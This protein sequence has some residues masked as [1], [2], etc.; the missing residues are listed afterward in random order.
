MSAMRSICFKMP[1]AALLLLLLLGACSAEPARAEV[2]AFPGAEGAGAMS[3]GGRGGRAIH[4][5]NLDDSGPGSLRSAID[6]SG[7]RTVIFDLGG[8]IRLQKPLTIAN[9]RI[10]IAGQTAPGGGITI[11]DHG[12]RI[13]A[14]DV[15]I[16]FFRSRLGDRSGADDDAISIISGHRIILDH[17]SASWGTDETLSP[18]PNWRRGEDLGDVTV[19][20]SIISES[21]CAP[22]QPKGI[23]CYGTLVG[24]GRGNRISLHHDLWADHSGRMPR[25]ENKL[26][27]SEDP[28]GGLISVRSNVFYNWGGPQV[29]Y[30]SGP[31]GKLSLNFVDNSYWQGPSS[32]GVLIYENRNPFARGW[33]SGNAFNGV[34][35]PDQWSQVL[36]RTPGFQLAGP[37]RIAPVTPDPA[38]SAYR[39]VLAGAGDSLARDSVDQRVIAGVSS[40]NGTLI[41][42][43]EQVGGWPSLASGTAWIDRDGDGLPDQWE[44]RHGLDPTNGAD[45]SRDSNGDGYTNLE[46]WLNSVAAPAMAR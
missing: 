33:F 36:S 5:S 45:S 3:L 30:D 19:Q 13:R 20:W 18:S 27:P 40:R 12:L 29:G 6:A 35:M 25:P 43:Q 21:L 26:S 1:G 46:E 9:G 32:K 44:S 17:V 15:V 14:D 37:V 24:T 4:V 2:P 23:H 28:V 34:V 11:R 16:R 22:I 8:T 31:P 41:D 39:R 38:A 10:T 7:P 42:S